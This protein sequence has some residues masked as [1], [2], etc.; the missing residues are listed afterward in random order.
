MCLLI[1]L[2][3]KEILR[4]DA[5]SGLI[6]IYGKNIEEL[7]NTLETINKNFRIL[8]EN[9]ENMF[10]CFDDYQSLKEEYYSGL[11]EFEVNYV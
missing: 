2:S 9:N 11:T 8:N 4:S 1:Y 5:C 3:V 7:C 6:G 10:I